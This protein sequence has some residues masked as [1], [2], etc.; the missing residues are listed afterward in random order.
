MCIYKILISIISYHTFPSSTGQLA[1]RL[2]GPLSSQSSEFLVLAGEK[3][4][5]KQLR[6]IQDF[7]V[8]EPFVTISVEVLQY[9]CDVMVDE[10]VWEVFAHGRQHLHFRQ[11]PIAVRVDRR[12]RYR[13]LRLWL[14]LADAQLAIAIPVQ[15]LDIAPNMLQVLL[16]YRWLLSLVARE[17]VR[18][19]VLVIRGRDA[20][21]REKT[22]AR[23]GR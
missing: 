19:Q 12:E 17:V 2:S 6:I 23:V 15:E 22:R 13:F 11:Q 10:R 7:A 18:S 21:T 8:R 16:G 20:C 5:H 9:V 4:E 3:L 14:Q 1:A